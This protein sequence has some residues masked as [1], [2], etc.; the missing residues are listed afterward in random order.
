[1]YLIEPESYEA[2]KRAQ[3][4]MNAGQPAS[5][6][7][8]SQL[9]QDLVG[10]KI[11]QKNDN[12]KKW[13]E[14][15]G[16]L[17]P[18]IT[19]GINEADSLKGPPSPPPSSG[20]PPLSTE[21]EIIANIADSISSNYVTKATRLYSL[22]RDVDGVRITPTQIFVNEKPLFGL[23]T[24][25]LSQLIKPTKYLSFNLSE[26]LYKIRNHPEITSLTINQQAKNILKSF[27]SFETSTPMKTSAGNSSD[28]SS[29]LS[30]SGLETPLGKTKKKA[31]KGKKGSGLAKRGRGRFCWK[32]LF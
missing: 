22:L 13:N 26:L 14:Y 3:M 21:E 9:N 6:I 31:K 2:L 29:F 24:T 10:S 20:S 18:I 1:M 15:A 8:V 11:L 7:K 12:V 28:R 32:S 19:Q 23:T 16:N 17:K 27:D 30:E 4:N 5:D 25:H